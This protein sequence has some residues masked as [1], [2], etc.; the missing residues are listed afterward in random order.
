MTLEACLEMLRLLARSS[1]PE[2]NRLMTAE[3]RVRGY[4]AE[5]ASP[6]AK[7]ALLEELDNA[8]IREAELREREA[9]FWEGIRDY[10]AQRLATLDYDAP[11]DEDAG[12]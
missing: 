9:S 11:T 12:Q 2:E 4:Y 8:V 6:D 5:A 7:R 10:I 3:P 1:E